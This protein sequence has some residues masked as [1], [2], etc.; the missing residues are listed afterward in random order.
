MRIFTFKAILVSKG[1]RLPRGFLLFP[2]GLIVLSR[3]LSGDTFSRASPPTRDTSCPL[4]ASSGLCCTNTVESTVNDSRCFLESHNLQLHVKVGTNG[5]LFS[6][7]HIYPIY[8]H[9]YGACPEQLFHFT[10][11]KHVGVDP[12][13]VTFLVVWAQF[14]TSDISRTNVLTCTFKVQFYLENVIIF[15]SF[16]KQSFL[17]NDSSAA[18]CRSVQT[19]PSFSFHVSSF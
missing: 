2:H 3:S 8:S 12:L 17:F 11:N 14:F 13:L 9:S 19:F 4:P 1:M 6:V 10:P 5:S 18:P 7:Y 16:C 15:V